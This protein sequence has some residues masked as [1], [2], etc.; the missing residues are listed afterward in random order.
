MI[1]KHKVPPTTKCVLEFATTYAQLYTYD[2]RGYRDYDIDPSDPVVPTGDDWDLVSAVECD[3]R[4]LWFW[5]RETW[6]RRVGPK[7]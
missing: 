6:P 7:Q 2:D 5:R 4:V 3:G 1:E